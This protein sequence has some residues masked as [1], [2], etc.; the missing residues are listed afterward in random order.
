MYSNPALLCFLLDLIFSHLNCV[1]HLLQVQWF[2]SRFSN[3]PTPL[4]S[5]VCAQCKKGPLSTSSAFCVF[6]LVS[7]T[8]YSLLPL[9]FMRAKSLLYSLVY[10]QYQKRCLIHRKYLLHKIFVRQTWHWFCGS[11]VHWLSPYLGL[12]VQPLRLECLTSD[13]SFTTY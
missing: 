8:P 11:R 5:E 13:P 1:I 3:I 2:L 12:C 9:S 6:L 7:I 4:V 10:P